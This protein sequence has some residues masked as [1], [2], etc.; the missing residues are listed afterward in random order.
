[1]NEDYDRPN[2]GVVKCAQIRMPIDI[3][4]DSVHLGKQ[5]ILLGLR[6]YTKEGSPIKVV[7]TLPQV[8]GQEAVGRRV[9]SVQYLNLGDH[10][11]IKKLNLL[12]LESH[13]HSGLLFLPN[14]PATVHFNN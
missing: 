10:R 13:R 2:V 6:L 1:M 5:D 7:S 3:C 8:S 9:T 14:V 11:I 12:G 4:F